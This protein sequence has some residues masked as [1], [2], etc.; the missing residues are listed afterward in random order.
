M[1]MFVLN[2]KG[3]MV[4]DTL[5]SACRRDSSTH[6]KQASLAVFSSLTVPQIHRTV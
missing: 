5:D 3:A 1:M 2:L 6:H 4:V